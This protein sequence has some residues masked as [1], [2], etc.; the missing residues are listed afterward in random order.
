[1]CFSLTSS[2]S[3]IRKNPTSPNKH[4]NKNLKSG[5]LEFF[6]PY[7]VTKILIISLFLVVFVSHDRWHPSKAN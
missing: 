4:V 1:M 3:S 7:F 6:P 5:I 2:N